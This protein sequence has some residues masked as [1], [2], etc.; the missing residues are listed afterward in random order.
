MNHLRMIIESVVSCEILTMSLGVALRFDQIIFHQI[1]IH[2]KNE[3][4]HKTQ[5]E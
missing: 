4:R 3:Q 2:Q 1:L 5:Y